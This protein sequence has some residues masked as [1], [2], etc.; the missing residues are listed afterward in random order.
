M[1]DSC[2]TVA[3]DSHTKY[4]TWARMT[5]GTSF[6]S[7]TSLSKPFRSS[8]RVN[9]ANSPVGVWGYAFGGRSQYL[10]ARVL[11]VEG[12]AYAMIAGRVEWYSGKLYNVDPLDFFS[13]RLHVI[14]DAHDG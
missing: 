11:K 10:V 6:T 12:F 13:L 9:F 14:A 5:F 3:K 1:I 7:S 2:S 8:P 4:G